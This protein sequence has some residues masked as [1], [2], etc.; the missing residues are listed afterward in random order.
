MDDTMVGVEAATPV[1]KLER[2]A[3]KANLIA[4]AAQTICAV[5]ITYHPDGNIFQH[6]ETIVGQVSQT[7]IVD[8]GSSELSV[9]Q[10][11][12]IADRLGVHLILNHENKGIARALNQ[13]AEWA[14]AAGYSWILTLDQDTMVASDMIESLTAVFL[15]YPLPQWLAVIGSNYTDKITGK[16]QTK[17]INSSD[18]LYTTSVTA[19]TSGSLVSLRVFQAIGGF[20]DD[21]FIDCVDHEYCLR[22]RSRGFE[23]A[24]TSKPVMQHGIGHMTE[25]R[26]LWKKVGTSNHDAARQYFMSRNSFLLARQYIGT[27][28][29]W[30]LGYMWAWLKSVVVI[31]LFEQAR[32]SKMKNIF[33][34]C[35]DGMLGRTSN[36]GSQ[37]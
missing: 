6:L 23:V 22:A 7:V 10:L 11:R 26:V 36:R 28:R 31:S 9:T 29:R 17:T 3:S 27:D 12:E 2:S 16:W 24:L 18:S 1:P 20:R 19:L 30:I 33:R 14:A 21:F 15:R 8:N 37:R 34:G 25:H 5:I 4:P 13:G 32:S 35:I